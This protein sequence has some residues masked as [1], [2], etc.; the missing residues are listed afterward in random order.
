MSTLD[1]SIEY[2]GLREAVAHCSDAVF[3]TDS[4]CRISFVNPAFT[5]LTGYSAEEA[6][7]RDASFLSEGS[8]SFLVD[9]ALPEAGSR[10]VTCRRPDGSLYVVDLHETALRN[11]TGEIVGWSV[12]M[13]DSG[14]AQATGEA[15]RFLRAMVAGS[16]DGIIAFDAQG[17]VLSW[18]CGAETIFGY[19]EEEMMGQSISR[20]V[21]PE[22]TELFH[23]DIAEVLRGGCVSQRQGICRDCSGHIVRVSVTL[24]PLYERPG[25]VAAISAVVRNVSHQIEAEEAQA[26]LAAIVES[27]EDAIASITLDG[28][29]LSWNRGAEKLLGYRRDEVMGEALSFLAMPERAEQAELIHQATL[30]GK[31]VGPYDTILRHRDGH[32]VEVSF[33]SFPVRN[34]EGRVIGTSGFARSNR[35]RLETERR[36]RESEARFRHIFEDSGSV[37]LLLELES[38]KI[39]AANQAAADFYGYS[40]EELS[41]MSITRINQMPREEVETQRQRVLH[42]KQLRFEFRHRLANGEEREVEVY[43]S[44]IDLEGRTMVLSIVHDITERNWIAAALTESESRFRRIFEE[45]GLVMVFFDPRNGLIVDANRAASAFY[46]YSHEQLVGMYTWQ[47]TGTRPEEGNA[48]R[49]QILEAGHS[50]VSLRHRLAGGEE[51]EVEVYT[52]SINMGGCPMIFAII[53]DITERNRVELQLRD[54]EEKLRLLTENIHELFWIMKGDGSQMQYLSPAFEDVWGLPRELVYRDMT[55][56]M[57]TIHPEDR[58]KAGETLARQLRGENVEFEFRIRGR[59]GEERWLRDRAFPGRGRD[60]HLLQVVGFTEDITESRRG[61]DALRESEQRYR[62]T[63]EQAAIGILYTAVDGKF[64]HCNLRFAEIIG[65]APEEVVGLGFQKIML[66]GDSIENLAAFQRL[67]QGETNVSGLENCFVRKDG[68]QVWVRLSISALRDQNGRLLHFITLVEDIHARK[69]AERLLQET[70]ERLSLATRAGGVGIWEYDLVR[71]RLVWDEQMGRLYG[72]QPESFHGSFEDWRER[73]HPEDEARARRDLDTTLRGERDFDTEFRVV[74]PDGSTHFIRAMALVQKDEA[75]KPLRLIGTN[76]DISA[77]KEAADAFLRS[78]RQLEVE[79]NRA[80]KLAE[81]A[82]KANAAK[83]E[84]L[85]NMSHEIRTPLNGVIGMTGLL[86]DTSL[87]AEQ[88]RYA[89]TIRASGESLLHLLNDILDFSRIEANRMDLEEV[90]FDLCELLDQTVGAVAAQALSKGL[91]LVV[92]V[93]GRVPSRVL[94]DPVR[95]RQVLANLLGNAIK[96]TAQGEIVTRLALL[97]FDSAKCLLRFTVRDTGIGI[98]AD[99]LQTVFEKFSQAEVSTTRR[100]GGTGLGLAI[101]KQLVERMGGEIGLKSQEGVGS[102]F[103]FTVR[104]G[105]G[106]SD[107]DVEEEKRAAEILT[108]KRV[109]IVDDNAAS[110][111]SLRSRI[112]LWGALVETA[113]N[114]PL[115]L[116]SVYLSFDAGVGPDLILIDLQMDGM[117]GEALFRAL[118]VDS[119]LDSLRRVALVSSGARYGV[120]RA[121]EAGFTLCVNKPVRWRELRR[122]LCRAMGVELSGGETR[123]AEDAAPLPNARVLLAEDNPTNQQVALGLLKKMGLRADAVGDGA[124]AIRALQHVPYDLVLMDMRMP[125]MDGVEAA[126]RIR[127]PHSG[128]LNPR[129]PILAMTANVQASDRQRCIDAGMNSFLSKPVLPEQLRQLLAEWLSASVVTEAAPGAETAVSASVPQLYDREGMLRRLMGDRS[130]AAV[131]LQAFLEDMPRQIAELRHALEENDPVTSGRQ[132]HSIKGAAA[133]VGG[134]RLRIL[135]Q[136]MEKAADQGDLDFLRRS[137]PELDSDFHEL[138]SAILEDLG[139]G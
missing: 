82:A 139:A 68:S 130:L 107:K 136:S 93:E 117:D 1:S 47:L 124:E 94:G 115:A 49:Q 125:V 37:M 56:L 79:K 21:A 31:T 92:E 99:K 128:V 59:Y 32:P 30:N 57:E 58:E 12:C 11:A 129:V 6:V 45:N 5:V 48:L 96:F 38:G 91:E 121:E 23:R 118:A 52:S 60:G 134:E 35:Q 116:Q 90:E 75:G 80:G 67:M 9:D 138:S 7:G 71:S 85:A 95:L 132:A 15:L 10:Q 28:R 36:L 33:S 102:E 98:P 50:R 2:S 84:F 61:Q 105:C 77:Q 89:E 112:A 39:V 103:S 25:Q 13:R 42:E 41:N 74:W 109:L 4:M 24:S 51:R 54:S 133:N 126:R 111:Q 88:H 106:C 114:A 120:R 55:L 83:S 119:R 8:K 26:L 66:P 65:Y 122:I 40:R 127:D 113:A 69:Q 19:S 18:N 62:A 100:F 104:M 73:L 87:S 108:G 137:I 131:V 123:R 72:V 3:L 97:D 101:C 29:V 46:G 44:A 22:E 78:N 43:S 53:H 14:D 64:L 110:C 16:E 34:A 17:R 27:S 135:A 70:S 86:L 81:E 63:F 20:I 76:W